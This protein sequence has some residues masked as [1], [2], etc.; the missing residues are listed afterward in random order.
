[1]LHHN[2]VWRYNQSMLKRLS[3]NTA[4]LLVNNMGVAILALG[5]SLLIG[6]GLGEV[7]LGQYAAVMAWI[8]PLTLLADAGI[9][10]LL[11]RDLAQHPERLADD[12]PNAHFWRL[13][14][15]GSLVATLWMMAPLLSHDATIVFGVQ[16]T[17][18]MIW[19]DSTFG[20]YTAIWRAKQQ[21]IPITVLN[22][23]LLSLQVAGTALVIGLGYGL[24]AIFGVIVLADLLQL[25]AAWGW[26]RLSSPSMRSPSQPVASYSIAFLRRALPFGIAGVLAALQGRLIFFLLQAFSSAEVI[27][28]FAAASRFMEAAKMPPFAFFGAFFPALMSLQGQPKRLAQTFRRSSLA[29]LLY[30]VVSAGGIILISPTL[31]RLTYGADFAEATRILTILGLSLPLLLFRQHLTTLYYAYQQEGKVNQLFLGGLIL[32]GIVGV[33]LLPLYPDGRGAA[34]TLLMGEAMLLGLLWRGNLHWAWPLGIVLVGIVLRYKSLDALAFDG[35]YG[36]DAFAYYNY[37]LEVKTA[38]HHLTP[39]AP[40]YWGLGLPTVL[41]L[42]FSIIPPSAHTAQWLILGMG[43]L[44]GGLMYLLTYDLLRLTEWSPRYAR[45]G[46]LIAALLFTASGQMIQ[47]SAVIM[48]DVPAVF[49]ALLSGWA[50][51]RFIGVEI[52][53]N[54]TQYRPCPSRLWMA[55][56]ALALGMAGITRW[57]YFVLVIPYGLILL[58][59]W[60]GRLQWKPTLLALVIGGM[61]VGIQA[62]HSSQQPDSVIGHQWVQEWSLRHAWQRHFVTADGTFDYAYTIGEFYTRPAWDNFYLAPIITPLLAVG[63]GM[64]LY[65]PRRYALLIL[66]LGG[67]YLGCYLF[68]IGVPYQ[69]IRFSLALLPPLAMLAA[70]GWVGLMAAVERWRPLHYTLGGITLLAVMIGASETYQHGQQALTTIAYNKQVDL[71]AVEWAEAR[72]PESDAHIFSLGLWLMMQHYTPRFTAL[73]L[74]YETPETLAQRDYAAHPSYLLINVW[75]I[76][77]Q[78]LGKSPWIAY[79]WLESNRGLVHLGRYGNYHLFRIKG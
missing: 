16:I 70:V 42:L 78:W 35:L 34:L 17:A 5:I 22:L 67:W 28:W 56:T 27:G 79:H 29:L 18:A 46:A 7:A 51:T 60:K 3:H 57:I 41:G 71:A 6:R 66:L 64:G 2:P 65:R 38:I 59:H 30:G 10:S 9:N 21:M 69:N 25:L 14:L 45:L 39:P 49:W 77:N 32:Q 43:A 54:R 1:M 50:L 73:Q 48:S 44:S 19:I 11:T 23:G 47:S 74:Y 72:I 40:M 55:L 33:W 15:G 31:I 76:E 12:L 36:Q 68:L 53:E 8:L 63:I 58:W 24:R 4:W 52:D 62:V 20:I 26:W 13:I 61:I 37:G 75:G